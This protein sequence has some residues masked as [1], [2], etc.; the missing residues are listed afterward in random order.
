MNIWG[1]FCAGL[2][3]GF[4]TD[5]HTDRQHPQ[6]K[7]QRRSDETPRAR[8]SKSASGKPRY[9]IQRGKMPMRTAS[10]QI[11]IMNTALRETGTP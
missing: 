8:K 9:A 11:D 5:V 1:D 10:V 7:D 6:R 4:A 2:D 3:R